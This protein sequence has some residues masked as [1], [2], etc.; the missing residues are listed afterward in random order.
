MQPRWTTLSRPF[1]I[2]QKIMN[3]CKGWEA[4][5]VRVR[6][7]ARVWCGR[8][9]HAF[10]RP[11]LGCRCSDV[12]ALFCGGGKS[13]NQC[14]CTFELLRGYSQAQLHKVWILSRLEQSRHY[15]TPYSFNRSCPASWSPLQATLGVTLGRF[16]SLVHRSR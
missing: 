12:P 5:E 16:S 8:L 11:E 6:Q 4:L 14:K 1:L 10:K 2:T 13:F 15:R 3:W 9:R 7:S